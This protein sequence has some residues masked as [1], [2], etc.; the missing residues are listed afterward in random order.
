MKKS[1]HSIEEEPI[2]KDES[3]KPSKTKCPRS[4]PSESVNREITDY[5]GAHVGP[6]ELEH[7]S[8]VHTSMNYCRR[9]H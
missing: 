2:D 7:V 3:N 6:G 5:Y 4:L 9:V 8:N 1:K